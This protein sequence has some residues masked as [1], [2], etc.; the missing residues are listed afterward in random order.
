[1][2]VSFIGGRNRSTR[3]K[4]PTCR[5]SL[6]NF[7]TYNRNNKGIFIENKDVNG[8]LK[9][10]G[11]SKPKALMEKKQVYLFF[12][13]KLLIFEGIYFFQYLF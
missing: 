6:T 13:K 3:R 12:N 9:R 1:V 4:P 11:D 10:G 7:I 2:A 8:K 5:K